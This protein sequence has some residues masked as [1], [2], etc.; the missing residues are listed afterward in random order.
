MH[1]FADDLENDPA[2]AK[3]LANEISP[4]I[5][6]DDFGKKQSVS[7]RIANKETVNDIAAKAFTFAQRHGYVMDSAP[8]EQT[9]TQRSSKTS[10]AISR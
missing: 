7:E 9:W 10:A 3:A 2:L 8:I 1:R 6:G 4:L 5:P